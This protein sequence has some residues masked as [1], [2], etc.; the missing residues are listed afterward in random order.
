MKTGDSIT[1]TVEKVNRHQSIKLPKTTVKK[2]EVYREVQKLDHTLV[3]AKSSSGN[4][5]KLKFCNSGAK[6][7][8]S[9]NSKYKILECK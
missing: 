5:F 6:Y 9:V 2:L 3:F 1:I 7:A 4:I 8:Y